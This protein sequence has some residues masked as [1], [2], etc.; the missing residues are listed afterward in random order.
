[1]KKIVLGLMTI[2]GICGGNIALSGGIET[3]TAP[4]FTGFYLGIN[5]GYWWTPG[6]P[7]NTTGTVTFINPVFPV[8]ASDIANALATVGSNA[9]SANNSGFIGGG[10]VGYDYQ[11]ASSFVVGLEADIDGLTQSNSS[12]TANKIVALVNF[13]EQYK[14]S[15]LANEKINYLGTVRARLGYLVVPTFLVY[16]SGG[17]GYGGVSVNTAVT[18]NESLGTAIYPTVSAQNNVNQTL[19][20]WCAGAGG[21]WMFYPH[22][23]AKIE[24]L[25]YGLGTLSNNL[26]LTQIL[27]T[28]IPPTTWG[29]ASVHSSTNV[30]AETIT[31]GLNY[32][33]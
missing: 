1:M 5:A 20:G 30:T 15:I 19:T 12:N 21:E 24:Y 22:L 28:A 2:A 31:V 10:Q 8:G 26:V 17:F 29:A 4:T 32:R 25:Y 23:S 27:N 7:V 33:F 18:A 13:P 11:F 9:I 6:N 16:A 3:V 14:T